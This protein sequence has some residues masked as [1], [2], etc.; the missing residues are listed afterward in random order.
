MVHYLRIGQSQMIVPAA[1]PCF[2]R[3]HNSQSPSSRNL[4]NVRQLNGATP[5]YNNVFLG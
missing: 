2:C 1:K 4:F 3:S 5:V